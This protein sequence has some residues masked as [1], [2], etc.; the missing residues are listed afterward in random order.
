MGFNR[1]IEFI[2]D[3]VDVPHFHRPL[4]LGLV[5]V[6]FSLEVLQ[7][8]IQARDGRSEACRIDG[9]QAVVAVDVWIDSFLVQQILDD[10]VIAV[11]G[12]PVHGC[13]LCCCAVAIRIC[14]CFDQALHN[15]MSVFLCLILLSNGLVAA[16]ASFYDRSPILVVS[17]L[18]DSL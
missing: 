9:Q 16:E 5:E 2:H 4:R 14:A 11:V 7:H 12:S 10:S 18:N 3:P 13:H 17:T 6:V 8:H 15:L 1:A